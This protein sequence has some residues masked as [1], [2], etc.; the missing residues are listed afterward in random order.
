MG[1]SPGLCKDMLWKG[2]QTLQRGQGCDQHP[3]SVL[4]GMG[5]KNSLV[6][7]RT[8]TYQGLPMPG[9]LLALCFSWFFNSQKRLDA[10]PQ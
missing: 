5:S 6:S 3:D 8:A 10:L 7:E 9:T 4:A 2:V 1:C